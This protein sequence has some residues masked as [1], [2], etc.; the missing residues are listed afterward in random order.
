MPV[1]VI[2]P[3]FRDN[4]ALERLLVGLE[5]G[6]ILQRMRVVFGEADAI[7]QVSYDR[8]SFGQIVPNFGQIIP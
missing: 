6:P 8:S 4:V 2:V 7:A 5:D 3:V 1:D